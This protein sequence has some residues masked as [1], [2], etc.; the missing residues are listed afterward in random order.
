MEEKKI[1]TLNALAEY[2]EVDIRT[3]YNWL[4]PIRKE[5]LD[6]YSPALNKKNL[7]LLLPKQIKKIKEYL[8]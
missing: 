7:S 1:Y 2:Y 3:I 6:M 5:L 8:G 4:K